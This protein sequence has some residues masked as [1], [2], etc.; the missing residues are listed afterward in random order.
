[1]YQQLAV[2]WNLPLWSP[3]LTSAAQFPGRLGKLFSLILSTYLNPDKY[4]HNW[5]VITVIFHPLELFRR[6]LHNKEAFPQPDIRPS[7]YNSSLKR[8][9]NGIV[10]VLNII[11]IHTQREQ[12]LRINYQICP[13][14]V[15]NFTL[16]Q[17]TAPCSNKDIHL[18]GK[19]CIR[20]TA[21][22]I[23]KARWKN[24]TKT[25]RFFPRCFFPFALQRQFK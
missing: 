5:K 8:A 6:H 15:C 22:S 18:W 23:L 20:N 19:C 10:R 3:L 9:P 7:C 17:T 1:M 16:T 14:V 12:G 24:K 11:Y 4:A 25:P 13:E 21:L 2:C